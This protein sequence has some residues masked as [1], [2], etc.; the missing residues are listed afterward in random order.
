MMKKLHILPTLLLGWC[1]L[2]FSACDSPVQPEVTDENR[3]YTGVNYFAANC[4]SLYY[5]W[6]EEIDGQLTRWLSRELET[7]PIRKVKEIRYKQNGKDFDRWTEVTDDY[8]AFT[9]G[10]E[11]VSTTYGCDIVLMRLDDTHVCAVVTIVYKNS[12]S[13]EKKKKK[14]PA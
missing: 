7:D 11:G 4:M 6:S 5:L 3:T 2:G 12:P 8:E 13:I 1:L 9:S 10:V 14:K